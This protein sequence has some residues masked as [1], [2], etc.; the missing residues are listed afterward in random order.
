MTGPI[1]PMTRVILTNSVVMH[2]QT[3]ILAAFSAVQST[4]QLLCPLILIIYSDNVEEKP[5]IMFFIFSGMNCVGAILISLLL[6]NQTFHENLPDADGLVKQRITDEDTGDLT[7]MNNFEKLN[8]ILFGDTNIINNDRNASIESIDNNN[9][10]VSLL[11]SSYRS[12][13]QV[14][15]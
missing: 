11:S 13:E 6:L 14:E 2:L 1:V 12:N 15:L 7:N 5:A 10:Y 8:A 4:S 9:F 3:T